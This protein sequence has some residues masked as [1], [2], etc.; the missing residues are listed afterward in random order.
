MYCYY[1]RRAENWASRH[2]F[3]LQETVLNRRTQTRRPR[4]RHIL[5]KRRYIS[6]QPAVLIMA[7]SSLIVLKLCCSYCAS[8]SI[9]P[10]R[11]PRGQQL[12]TVMVT[13]LTDPGRSGNVCCSRHPDGQRTPE[14]ADRRE[15]EGGKK[16]KHK[17][18]E[19]ERSRG[20]HQGER[21]QA[22]KV[23]QVWLAIR[24]GVR[25][26]RAPRACAGSSPIRRQMTRNDGLQE[27]RRTIRSRLRRL[28]SPRARGLHI[29]AAVVEAHFRGSG[30]A[31]RKR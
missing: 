14:M 26:Q 28:L 7:R 21:N 24:H 23:R 15:M 16:R 30:A 8:P 5:N 1:L 18:K 22:P 4:T 17:K 13:G 31:S 20:R 11:T 29:M 25:A 19:M 3:I 9:P 12:L 27:R 10:G 6:C 2:G